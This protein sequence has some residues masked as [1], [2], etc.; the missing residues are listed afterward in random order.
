LPKDFV[1][2]RL[3]LYDGDLIVSV[4]RYI[5][6]LREI[7]YTKLASARIEGTDSQQELGPVY[8]HRGTVRKLRLKPL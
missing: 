4:R 2:G 1:N 6:N 5:K 8:V 3:K 7:E